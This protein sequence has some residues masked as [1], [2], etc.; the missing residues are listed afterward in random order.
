[1]R[2]RKRE[3]VASQLLLL[4]SALAGMPAL[5]QEAPRI[6]LPAAST[7]RARI[8]DEV[9]CAVDGMKMRLEADTPSAELEGRT[10][11]FCS[12]SEKEEFLRR[13]ARG[14]EPGGRPP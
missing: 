14:N 10:Y 4:L 2:I 3:F 5:G 1:M 12:E 8:G 13:R 9:T 6:G 7:P 11:Y